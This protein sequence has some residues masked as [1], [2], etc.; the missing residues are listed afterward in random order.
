MQK[1]KRVVSL[2]LI[3]ML[4]VSMCMIG[5]TSAVAASTQ[6][7][8]PKT[9]TDTVSVKAGDIVTY[10]VYVQSNQKLSA[11][12][13]KTS[14]NSVLGW[15]TAFE[16]DMEDFEK[17]ISYVP[18]LDVL[19]GIANLHPQSGDRAFL[20]NGS[21]VNRTINLSTNTM[22]YTLVFE[23]QSAGSA[24][25]TTNFLEMYY[26]E[27]SAKETMDMTFT[28]T[29]SVKVNG[30]TAPTSTTNP[31][32]PP[33][34]TNPPQEG[35]A[36]QTLTNSFAVT[37]GDTVTYKVYVQSDQDLSGYNANTVYNSVL[38][39]D[40]EFEQDM[41]DYDTAVTYVPAMNAL[42]AV[43]NLYPQSGEKAFFTN[44]SS[45]NRTIDLSTDTMLYTLVFEAQSTG[46]ASLTTTLEEMYYLYGSSKETRDMTFSAY[47][48]VEVNGS[49]APTNPPT[50]TNPPAPTDPPAP[51]NPPEEGNAP[52]TLTNSFAVTKGDTV[53]YK[54]YVQS[55]Q[56]LSGY[57]ANTVYNSVLGWDSEFEQ[58]MQDYDT[59]VTY[60]PAMNALGAVANLYPQSGEKAFFTNGSSV[61]RTIDLST[62]TMLYTLVF[63]ATS[64]GTA[65]LTTT[66][67]EMYYLYGAN[68]E[69]RD[70]TFTATASVDV[71]GSTQP[72]NPETQPGQTTAPKTVTDTVNVQAG[73][74]VTYDVYVTSSQDLSVFDL[75]TTYNSVLDWETAFE[76]AINAENYGAYMSALEP[77]NLVAN[78]NPS[79]GGR[80]F[81]ANGS[82]LNQKVDLNNTKI[83]TLVF[84]AKTTGTASI[85]TT[86]EEMFYTSGSAKDLVALPFSVDTNISVDGSEKPTDP[87]TDGGTERP[88]EEPTA[89]EE[90]TAPKTISN[91]IT[92][93]KGDKVTYTLYVHG[94]EKMS[95]Y[96]AITTY[97]DVL[98]WD[99]D[100]EADMAD[101]ETASTYIPT[102][103]SLGA[104][105]NLYPVAGDLA[106]LANGS[107]VNRTEDITKG[108]T[109]LYTLVFE[110]VKSGTVTLTTNMKE[111]YYLSNTA[112]KD[113]MDMVFTMKA[114]IE[115]EGDTPSVYTVKFVDSDNNVIET[116]QVQKGQ[117]ADIPVTPL[118]RENVYTPQFTAKDLQ[119]ITSN[120]TFVYNVERKVLNVFSLNSDV[121]IG[122][123]DITGSIEYGEILTLTYT[124]N[125][126]FAGWIING[127]IVS[128][129]EEYSTYIQ[130]D[131]VIDV[132]ISDEPVGIMTY[133]SENVIFD[134]VS[135][136]GEIYM[137]FDINA[138]NVPQGADVR[139]GIYR[140]TSMT[141]E[142]TVE[143]AV[144]N[145]LNGGSATSINEYTQGGYMNGDGRYSYLLSAPDTI[146]E[147][148]TLYV[149]AWIE[150]DGVLYVSSIVDVKPAEAL[151]G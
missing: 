55:D 121:E 37:K 108:D 36:P 107:S 47:A 44:G 51:T 58:D 86:F 150:V 1:V 123:A 75:N 109:M 116:Q 38:G 2:M 24:T 125:D 95:A 28:A 128:S 73:D 87:P 148:V 110:A 13:V 144:E 85:S 131:A 52:Q 60:V 8:A 127:N 78:A 25:I 90:G 88:T 142:L 63:E 27:G 124:G 26:L 9:L 62:N 46:T 48:E 11:Y 134:T 76:N 138:I 71:N 66:L 35:N 97:G 74:I 81:N 32:D 3:T 41:Q 84:E 147:N 118:S 82:S 17:S 100:F 99:A 31:T 91:T 105:I 96:N 106:F 79:S 126:S 21:S 4:I 119:N 69:T 64:T 20:S 117:N 33:A 19:G 133:V 98:G 130:E 149:S 68:K 49:V 103:D 72:T 65:T 10:E 143:R 22:F 5:V 135:Q 83:F 77:L 120:K 16:Q 54:V 94:N 122:G 42:G 29:T 115:I 6:G 12:N 34:P 140:S 89:T 50:S 139:Y 57:N 136:D 67:E 53:T 114:D 15:D 30:S 14:Y 40:S 23:A 39:W 104:V 70:M 93:E 7:T 59:A 92:V 146:S 43:A 80:I 102:Y 129:D 141:T 151:K 18:A 145:Y 61:N 112:S 111:M 113:T 45:V 132:F 137:Y 101:F 56:D